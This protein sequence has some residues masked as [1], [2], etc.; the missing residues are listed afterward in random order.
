MRLGGNCVILYVP[1]FH[2]NSRG[3]TIGGP[4]LT[5]EISSPKE[6]LSALNCIF[7]KVK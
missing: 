5:V 1:T 4:L 6:D 7:L 3:D 2:V